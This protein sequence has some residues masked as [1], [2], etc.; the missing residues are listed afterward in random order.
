[1]Q[2]I[3]LWTLLNLLDGEVEWFA[4]LI[5]YIGGATL[6]TYL[7]KLAFDRLVAYLGREGRSAKMATLQA[8]G[9]PFTFYF[10]FLVITECL[11]IVSDRFLTSEF[12]PQMKLVLGVGAI[13]SICWILLRFKTLMIQVVIERRQRQEGRCDVARLY[14]L[15]RLSTLV[16]V[17][18]AIIVIL[19]ITDQNLKTIVAFGG[20]SGLAMAFAS[21]EILANFFWGI[22]LHINQPFGVGEWILL[23]DT[24]IE[25]VV[26]YIGWYQTRIRGAD[27]R[28]I[29]IPNT[30]LSKA[31]VINSSRM[32]HRRLLLTLAVRHEDLERANDIIADLENYLD[33]HP[34]I[35]NTGINIVHIS[36]INPYSTDLE[37]K[38]L[39]SYTDEK[40]FLK[41]RDNV[42]EKAVELIYKHN[43]K[44]A[45]LTDE[46]PD[47]P[48]F[49]AVTV[50]QSDSMTP[51]GMT[52][53]K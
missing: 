35:D 50:K 45:L 27:K 32:T 7:L 3:F 44:L 31:S 37:I 41:L 15:S 43:A 23:P 6:I 47:L 42:I 36:N 49:S 9:K 21:Q 5:V 22:M 26:E 19:E 53:S 28:P 1:M 25:G 34:G 18:I 8:I 39:S 30:L 14:A 10:W 38:A 17:V 16:V 51:Y 48:N 33:E 46:V 11:D 52:K 24:N 12:H 2:I 40:Q 29:Y 20:I 4:R 13:I